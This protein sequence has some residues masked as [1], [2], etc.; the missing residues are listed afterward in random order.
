MNYNCED[1]RWVRVEKVFLFLPRKLD[2]GK[3]AWLCFVNKET[4]FGFE[5]YAGLEPLATY[6][7]IKK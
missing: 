4:D 1:D 6:K 3:W 5:E 2:D 7:R